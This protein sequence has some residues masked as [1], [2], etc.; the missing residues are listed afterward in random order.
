MISEHNEIIFVKL[1][2]EIVDLVTNLNQFRSSRIWL[3]LSARPPCKQPRWFTRG[4]SEVDLASAPNSF[5][6]R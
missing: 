4:H 2:M 5:G 6:G 1:K 3:G